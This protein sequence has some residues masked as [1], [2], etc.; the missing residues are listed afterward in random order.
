MTDTGPRSPAAPRTALLAEA[1]LTGVSLATVAG[2]ARLFTDAGY[3]APVAAA[4]VLGHVL[5]AGLRRVGLGPVLATAVH[6]AGLAL[7][8]AWGR[9]LSTTANLVPTGATLDRIGDDLAR[10]WDIFLDVSAPVPTAPGFVVVAMVAAWVVALAADGLAFRLH[11]TAEAVAPATGLF[12]FS[13]I[14]AD[15]R[16]R[17]LAATLFVVSVLAFVLAARV[18]RATAEGAGWRPTPA[19]GPDR[20]WPPA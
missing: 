19:G 15:D 11:A 1:A 18:A 7:L 14:L 16:H 12:L 20:C 6:L 3:V 4:A 5:A 8:L 10:S 2:Y 17:V 13:S 9:Y